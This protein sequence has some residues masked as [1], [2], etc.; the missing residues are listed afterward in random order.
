MHAN[1]KKMQHEVVKQEVLQEKKRKEKKKKCKSIFSFLFQ[2][3]GKINFRYSPFL[4]FFC[5][6]VFW[7]EVKWSEVHW[8]FIVFTKMTAKYEKKKRVFAYICS[9]SSFD[10]VWVKFRV[11]LSS[12][13]YF[14][15]FRL[16]IRSVLFF[17]SF[18]GI[19][20]ATQLNK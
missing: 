14:F 6:C 2:F 20:C 15:F 5:S 3:S 8:E 17:L 10:P 9:F 19:F 18:W 12:Y 7:S 16:S 11:N 4:S 13:I 1:K